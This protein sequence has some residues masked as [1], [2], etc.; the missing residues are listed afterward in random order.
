MNNSYTSMMPSIVKLPSSRPSS[1]GGGFARA[2]VRSR[3]RATGTMVVVLEENNNYALSSSLQEDCWVHLQ[4]GSK[5]P[6]DVHSQ[7]FPWSR[8]H[9]YLVISRTHAHVYF[10]LSSVLCFC[11]PPD[12]NDKRDLPENTRLGNTSGWTIVFWHGGERDANIRTQSLE[13]EC[14]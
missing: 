6:E 4:E 10:S 14:G 3:K 11:S 7:V 9:T 5:Y 12:K 8:P 2:P 1:I 13:M